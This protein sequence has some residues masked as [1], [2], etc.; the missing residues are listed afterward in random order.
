MGRY[1]HLSWFARPS[2]QDRDIAMHALQL[3]KMEKF[4]HRHISQLSGG[5]Q[6]RVFLAR[7]LAQQALIFILDEP[8]VGIDMITERLIL[9][10]LQTL[11]SEG[12]TIIVV[13][14]D[15]ATV[16]KYFD[17]TFLMNKKH[18]ALGKTQDVL[19]EQNI[20]KT[21]GSQTLFNDSQLYDSI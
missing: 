4:A 8:F 10:L 15:L 3:V 14:H 20:I 5:Q 16:K 2:K 11:R 21:F 18:I 12:K 7:A 19:T 9:E 6:Q 1:S 17:W 13:H